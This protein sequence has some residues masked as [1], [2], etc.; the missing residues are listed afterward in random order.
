MG[1]EVPM[2]TNIEKEIEKARRKPLSAEKL[3]EL[4]LKLRKNA[5]GTLTFGKLVNV[6][7]AINWGIEGVLGWVPIHYEAH[8]DKKAL[9]VL[10]PRER[11]SNDAQFEG[12]R[13]DLVG[14]SVAALPDSPSAAGERVV[15]NVS[16]VRQSDDARYRYFTHDEWRG[17][18]GVVVETSGGDVSP[19]VLHS[20]YDVTNRMASSLTPNMLVHDVWKWMMNNGI[21]EAV[22]S[23][24][25]MDVHV[26][27]SERTRENTG[28]CPTCWGNYKLEGGK[29]VMHGYRRPGYG[30]IQ[31][32][33][34]AVGYEPV[35]TS[36]DGLVD[37]KNEL[38]ESLE[39]TKQELGAATSGGVKQIQGRRGEL[40]VLGQPAFDDLLSGLI[41]NLKRQVELVGE[42]VKNYGKLIA[43]WKPRPMP[44]EGEPQRGMGYFLK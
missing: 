30:F 21:E 34:F 38:E 26:P 43:A 25:D 28:T 32:R 36:S 4:L 20:R 1:D 5:T 15:M 33:C 37:F 27:A 29:L 7:D 9:P 8:G 6:V 16:G 18:E 22:S 19:P 12:A 39:L 23:A 41:R 40:I 44:K 13:Q 17:A 14:A 2:V 42:E 10:V 11:F 35:E 3:K 24:L 31:G